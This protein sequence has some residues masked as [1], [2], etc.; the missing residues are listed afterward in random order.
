MLRQVR[1]QDLSKSLA[2]E[3]VLSLLGGL[4]AQKE[5]HK[6]GTMEPYP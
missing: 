1:S 2:L 3:S 5:K 4:R 6:A